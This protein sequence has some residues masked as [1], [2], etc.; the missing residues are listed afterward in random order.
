MTS[1]H[2]NELEKQVAKQEKLLSQLADIVCEQAKRIV[3]LE[4]KAPHMRRVETR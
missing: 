4:K 2:F 3:A 1:H